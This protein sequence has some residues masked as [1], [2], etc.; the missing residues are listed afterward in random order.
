VYQ[1]NFKITC[2]VPESPIWKKLQ[3]FFFRSLILETMKERE[4][5]GM[6]ET[7]GKKGKTKR[8]RHERSS[9]VLS[10]DRDLRQA[11]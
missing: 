9:S 4:I 10:A 11:F 2:S 1:Q 5:K 3:M 7:R 6:D 8:W